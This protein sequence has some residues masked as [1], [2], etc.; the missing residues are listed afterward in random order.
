VLEILDRPD[1]LDELA[2]AVADVARV[3]AAEG[4]ELDPVD[5]FDPQAFVRADAAAIEASW[6]SQRRY[7]RNLEARRTGVWRDLNVHHRP[8]ELREILGPVLDRA[9]A[10]GVAVPELERLYARVEAAERAD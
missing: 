9:R 3:A 6:E 10:R 7:W 1:L 4:V 5:G 8:T 2:R